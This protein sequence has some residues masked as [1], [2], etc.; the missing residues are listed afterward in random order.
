MSKLPDAASQWLLADRALTPIIA[1]VPLPAPDDD[2]ASK[3]EPDRLQTLTS[4]TSTAISAFDSA[5][6]LGLGLPQR[7]IVESQSGRP[8]ILHAYLNPPTRKAQKS[9]N[10]RILDEGGII[11]QAREDHRPLTATT[12]GHSDHGEQTG[13][14]EANGSSEQAIGEVEREADQDEDDSE[15]GAQRSPLLIASVVASSLTDA[16]KAIVGLE[17]TGRDIQRALILEQQH[18][19]PKGV[20]GS[21]SG[22]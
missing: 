6:R 7:I 17:R 1:S 2:G 11:E 10:E 18:E 20:I 16:R 19:D 3:H 15:A 12:D 8:V 13:Q 4:L 14:P 5:A 9:N 21:S 22:E